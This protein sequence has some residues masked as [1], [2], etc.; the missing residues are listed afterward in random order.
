[1][2]KVATTHYQVLG[3]EAVTTGLSVGQRAR[4]AGMRKR[5]VI[6]FRNEIR[7][8]EP[9]PFTREQ[10]AFC[11]SISARH[12]ESNRDQRAWRGLHSTAT[13]QE[14]S[15]VLRASGTKGE[16][17]KRGSDRKGYRKSDEL[18][19]VKKGVK[20]SG[21]KELGWYRVINELLSQMIG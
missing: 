12:T 3:S 10:A 7:K 21:A 4:R 6:E 13:K 19:V 2:G 16:S 17:L 5:E 14:R 15:C 20:A 11:R 9:I 8:L 1:M 18:I